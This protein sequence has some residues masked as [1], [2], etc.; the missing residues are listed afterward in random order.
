M[1]LNDSSYVYLKKRI[2]LTY[3]DKLVINTFVQSP[4][5]MTKV[6]YN[7][8]G[9]ELKF[10]NLFMKE[11][12]K[13]TDRYDGDNYWKIEF[14][15]SDPHIL[16]VYELLGSEKSSGKGADIA[17]E[18]VPLELSDFVQVSSE[19]GGDCKKV[20]INYDKCH[21]VLFDLIMKEDVLTDKHRR[22]YNRIDYIM[23]EYK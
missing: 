20:W 23:K 7:Y 18:E 3:L 15:R 4:I 5:Q 9:E 16:Q 19:G 12:S 21:Q 11:L 10:S 13:I 6:L 14:G 1:L 2:Q 22:M 17:Y 8:C